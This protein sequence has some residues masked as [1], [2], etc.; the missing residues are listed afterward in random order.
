MDIARIYILVVDDLVDTADTTVELLSIWGYN[1]IACYSGAT[2]LKSVSL[3]PPSAVI[4]DLAMPR[5]DGFHFTR[6]FHKLPGCG[7][8][9]IIA[10]SG[11]SSAAY[12]SSAREVGILHYLVKPADPNCLKDILAR[13]IEAK[14]VPNPLFGSIAS[15]LAAEFWQQA[16]AF[17]CVVEPQLFTAPVSKSMVRS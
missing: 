8:I 17:P 11:Y 9:P 4:L 5:M 3:H 10:L 1:A 12:R 2:A 13:E 14:E 6:L 7:S 16:K 15:L